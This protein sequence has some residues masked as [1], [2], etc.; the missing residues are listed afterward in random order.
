MKKGKIKLIIDT[1]L[2]V[3]YAFK[4]Q[5]SPLSIVLD[6]ED[7]DILGSEELLAELRDVLDR[8]RI[9][10]KINFNSSQTFLELIELSIEIIQVVSEV[11]ACRDPKDNFLLA[12]S[13]DGKA[14]ALIT[15]DK[16]LLAIGSFEE[17]KILTLPDFL[18]MRYT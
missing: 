17:T 8:P 18:A 3:S 6:D 4:G 11:N 14:D 15:G 5:T 9:K 16:D 10:E 2:W 7:V 1:N 13:K 12:L